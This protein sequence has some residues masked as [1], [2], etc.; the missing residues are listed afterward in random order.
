[1]TLLERLQQEDLIF[2]VD[3]YDV[4]GFLKRW[5]RELSL[6]ERVTEEDPVCSYHNYSHLVGTG[7]IMEKLISQ[8][9]LD[10]SAMKLGII[11]ALYH[12]FRYG[13]FKND[14]DNIRLTC[15]SFMTTGTGIVSSS[16]DRTIINSVIIQTRYPYNPATQLSYTGKVLRDADRLYGQ[17]FCSPEM[18]N[19]LYLARGHIDGIYTLEEFVIRNLEFVKTFESFSQEGKVLYEQTKERSIDLHLKMLNIYN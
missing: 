9:D 8:T 6:L 1:M 10:H 7:M 12:D 14:D 3:G 2:G 11:A 18:I 19:R 13:G 15:N 16:I 4:H 17:V 5:E